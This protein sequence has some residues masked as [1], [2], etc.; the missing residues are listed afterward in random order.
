MKYKLVST[1]IDG[2][3]L[4]YSKK[5]ISEYT[6]TILSKIVEKGVLVVPNTGRSDFQFPK[7]FIDIGVR[8]AI[9]TNGT[10]IKDL[11]E[12][13]IIFKSTLDNDVAYK[14]YEYCIDNNFMYAAYINDGCFTKEDMYQYIPISINELMRNTTTPIDNLEEMLKDSNNQITKVCIAFDPIYQTKVLNDLKPIYPTLQFASAMI[15]DVEIMNNDAGKDKGLLRLLEYLNIDISEV[16]AMG[17]GDNDIPV[18]SMDGIYAI[19]PKNGNQ[20]ALKYA[21]VIVDS[22]DENGP[23]KQLKSLIL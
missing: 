23:A 11:K 5:E 22:D 12:N 18:L 19:V 20:G 14:M 17:D 9:C 21:D 10:L 7:A 8:Y 4:P 16:I 13:K 15:Y 1:D 3:L 6:L 2:T